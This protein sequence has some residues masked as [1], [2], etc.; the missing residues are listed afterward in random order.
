MT[1]QDAGNLVLL[2]FA[3]EGDSA[4]SQ[5]IATPS[6]TTVI[7]EREGL[8]FPNASSAYEAWNAGAYA[9][10]N[11]TV[12]RTESDILNGMALTVEISGRSCGRVNGPATE[13]PERIWWRY[14]APRIS[15]VDMSAG[16]TVE[17]NGDIAL[18]A[19]TAKTVL[20]VINAANSL[21]RITGAGSVL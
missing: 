11:W 14:L 20:S 3:S 16:Y 6:G 8:V 18:T 7:V 19:A 13:N 2:F 15:E 1:V 5:T 12:T 10:G 4:D 21:I 17:S 9:P